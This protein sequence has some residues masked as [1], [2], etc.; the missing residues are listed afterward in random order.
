MDAWRDRDPARLIGVAE[1]RQRAGDGYRGSD[2]ELI[3]RDTADRPLMI[4]RHDG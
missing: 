4:S 3:F 1:E 2:T